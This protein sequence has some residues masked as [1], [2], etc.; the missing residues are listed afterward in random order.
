MSFSKQR[1][2]TSILAHTPT[3]TVSQKT[4]PLWGVIARCCSSAAKPGHIFFLLHLY[5]K[6]QSPSSLL[7]YV[8]QVQSARKSNCTGCLELPETDWKL[9]AEL[10]GAPK[11]L[12]RLCVCVFYTVCVC[13]CVFLSHT[14]AKIILCHFILHVLHSAMHVFAVCL[15]M[16]RRGND[17]HLFTDARVFALPAFSSPAVWQLH[18]ADPLAL[19]R[20][21]SSPWDLSAPSHMPSGPWNLLDAWAITPQ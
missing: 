16:H 4:H 2:P 9:R 10:S 3:A 19:W 11:G 17:M 15:H 21:Q 6:W 18:R 5:L 12:T 7:N 8:V 14:A 20:W 13:I 1:R